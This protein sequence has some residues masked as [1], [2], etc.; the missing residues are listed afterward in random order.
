MCFLIDTFVAN[1]SPLNTTMIPPV[2]KIIREGKERIWGNMNIK[3][4]LIM[5]AKF[6]DIEDKTSE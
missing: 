6:R 3:S 4:G 2:Q 5:K 1:I